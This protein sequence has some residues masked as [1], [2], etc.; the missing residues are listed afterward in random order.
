MKKRVQL[1][2]AADKMPTK[3][4]EAKNTFYAVEREAVSPD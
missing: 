1:T 4:Q 2:A 3:N